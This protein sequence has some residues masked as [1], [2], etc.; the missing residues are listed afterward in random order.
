MVAGQTVSQVQLASKSRKTK[1]NLRI[2]VSRTPMGSSATLLAALGVH[3]LDHEGLV[4]M[5][6]TF[7]AT[8]G[9]VATN[10]GAIASGFIVA[11]RLSRHLP[12]TATAP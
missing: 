7:R 9:K 1:R 2:F 3:F 6:W 12:D 8:C 11:Q 10:V 4:M 5:H